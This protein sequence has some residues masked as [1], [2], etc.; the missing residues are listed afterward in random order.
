MFI[1]DHFGKVSSEASGYSQM[2]CFNKPLELA[3]FKLHNAP[4]RLNIWKKLEICDEGNSNTNIFILN[5]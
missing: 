4:K 1:F 2:S 3:F 5:I